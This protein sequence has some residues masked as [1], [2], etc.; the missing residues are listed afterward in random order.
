MLGKVGEMPRTL[1]DRL[2]YRLAEE[3]KLDYPGT[4]VIGIVKFEQMKG[5]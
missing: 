1:M 3:V 5:R 4:E 2:I